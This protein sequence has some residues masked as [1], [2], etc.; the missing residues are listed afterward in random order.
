MNEKIQQAR[1]VVERAKAEY[2]RQLALA[3][4][5][6]RVAAAQAADGAEGDA[7]LEAV[8]ALQAAYW[9]G[10]PVPAFGRLVQRKPEHN[11]PQMPEGA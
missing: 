9:Q 5:L 7:D 2:R 4:K 10:E 1:Q 11:D 3:D 6:L 8:R